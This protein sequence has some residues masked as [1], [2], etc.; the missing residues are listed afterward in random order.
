MNCDDKI[1]FIVDLNIFIVFVY[2]GE[3]PKCLKND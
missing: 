1:S 2:P 3:F